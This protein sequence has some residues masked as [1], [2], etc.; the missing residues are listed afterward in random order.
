MFSCVFVKRNNE[1]FK[2]NIGQLEKVWN[3]IEMER[4]SGYEHRAPRQ[5]GSSIDL[6]KQETPKS[7]EAIS[8]PNQ[9]KVI[10]LAHTLP[11]DS[12]LDLSSLA[13]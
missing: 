2:N 5:R 3:I 12:R 7:L 1:W 6:S 11:E 8:N 4:I 10:K 9:I 13:W